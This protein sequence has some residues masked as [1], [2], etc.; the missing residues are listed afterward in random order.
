MNKIVLFVLIEIPRIYHAWPD[1]PTDFDRDSVFM[2][3]IFLAKS[4]ILGC[5]QCLDSVNLQFCLI[6][7]LEPF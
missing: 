6:V 7:S 4:A 3:C 2:Q 1:F 5:N